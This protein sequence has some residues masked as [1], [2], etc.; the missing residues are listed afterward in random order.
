MKTAVLQGLDK[1]TARISTF[2]APVGQTVKFG[3]LEITARKCSK[4]RPEE[5]PEN[6][7]FLEIKEVGRSKAPVNVF[8]G[9]MFS[10]SPAASAMEHPVYDVWITSCK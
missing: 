4:S 7:A 9:W 10:S 2:D 3:S 8:N 5:L 6:A 1:V